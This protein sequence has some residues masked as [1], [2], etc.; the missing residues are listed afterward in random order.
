MIPKRQWYMKM[1]ENIMKDIMQRKERA[2]EQ[3][4]QIIGW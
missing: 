1:Q 3:D 4:R 2:F